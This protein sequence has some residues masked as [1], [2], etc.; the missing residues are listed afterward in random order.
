MANPMSTWFLT[1]NRDERLRLYRNGNM[2]KRSSGEDFGFVKRVKRP[3]SY[4]INALQEHVVQVS[5]HDN[6]YDIISIVN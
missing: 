4:S 2:A 1:P 6:N 3:D 5:S